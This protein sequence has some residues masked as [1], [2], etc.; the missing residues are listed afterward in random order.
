MSDHLL[1]R[2]WQSLLTIVQNQIR[3]KRVRGGMKG[4]VRMAEES[5]ALRQLFE[6]QLGMELGEMRRVSPPPGLIRA[7]VVSRMRPSTA[8][9]LCQ[10]YILKQCDLTLGCL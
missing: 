3:C 4:V 8:C 5:P 6:E 1:S 10:V 2:Y 9:D 7:R